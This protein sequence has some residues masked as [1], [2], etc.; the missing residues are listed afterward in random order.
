[1]YSVNDIA[2]EATFLLHSL[3]LGIR[4]CTSWNYTLLLSRPLFVAHLCWSLSGRFQV[5]RSYT[6][7]LCYL[8][9][10]PHKSPPAPS[11]FGLRPLRSDL[12]FYIRS[13]LNL[14]RALQSFWSTLLPSALAYSASYCIVVSTLAYSPPLFTLIVLC[15]VPHLSALSSSTLAYST[16]HSSTAL[17]FTLAYS[18]PLF[19][20]TVLFSALH[21][22]ALPT[23]P[24]PLCT[25]CSLHSSLHSPIPL[26]STT[27][28]AALV[29][30]LGVTL[31]LF[32]LGGP[33]FFLVER[34]QRTQK[35]SRL[36]SVT[37]ALYALSA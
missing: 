19:T 12:C 6:G 34:L 31:L 23:P 20:L 28:H 24:T 21:S 7:L 5:Y 2:L 16:L 9:V 33:H 8:P 14:Y 18:T 1:M 15:T 37:I 36:P 10:R 35:K 27:L 17:I 11:L 13:S 22:S 26:Y 4:D 3:A 25:A 32:S 30:S 29:S